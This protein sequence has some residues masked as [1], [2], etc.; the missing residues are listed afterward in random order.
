MNYFNLIND[1]P[2]NWNLKRVKEIA[3]WKIGFTPDSNNDFFYSGDDVWVTIGD[4]NDKYI[5]D[6]KRKIN[7]ILFNKKNKIPEN[8]LLFSFKLSIGQVAFNNEPIFTNEAICSFLKKSKINLNYFY[9]SAPIFIVKNSKKNIYNADLLNQNLIANSVCLYPPIKEQIKISNFL[10]KN[11]E[12]IE[13]EISLLE[14]KSQLLEEYKQSLIFETV[15]KGLDKNAEMKDSGID[16]IGTTPKH[17]KIKRIKN[18]FNSLGGGNYGEDENV[19][20]INLPCI[21]ISDFKNGNII[22]T[23]KIVS[24][25]S[26]NKNNKLKKGT[27]LLEKSGGGEKNPVGRVIYLLNDINAHYTNFVQGLKSVEDSKFS[28][29]LMKSI[30]SNKFHM[31]FV[32]QNTGLQNFNY[33]GFSKLFFVSIPPKN[34]QIDIVSFLDEE[35]QKIEDKIALI[36]KKVELLKEYKQSLIYEAVTG[37]LDIE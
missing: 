11:C 25:R 31:N 22:N 7:G 30:H 32:K 21:S 6:S 37:Q 3:K 1:N 23:D 17:W 4:M 28:Y 10:D 24:L 20:M 12:K 19:S 9:Y 15:T 16:W 33:N 18:I 29:Y 35:T 8:S 34:E 13:K 5:K 27:I 36:S 2:K 14:R 26:Y